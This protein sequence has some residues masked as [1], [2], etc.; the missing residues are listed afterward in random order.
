MLKKFSFPAIFFVLILSLSGCGKTDY[1]P[2]MPVRKGEGVIPII[3]TPDPTYHN[4]NRLA[5]K[6]VSAYLYTATR[7]IEV[8]SGFKGRIDICVEGTAG[9]MR[10]LTFTFG[11]LSSHT[12]D[13]PADPGY[14][15]LTVSCPK[16]T[17]QGSFQIP[18]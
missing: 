1:A 15:T 11:N 5:S 16:W 3:Y 13:A 4:N 8:I 18:E 17:E 10:A 9:P 2:E 7:E 12:F 14:Y 6:P